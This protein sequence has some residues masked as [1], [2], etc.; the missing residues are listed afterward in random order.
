MNRFRLPAIQTR[1]AQLAIAVMAVSLGWALSPGNIKSYLILSPEAVRS[2]M[3]WQCVSYLFIAPT[4]GSVFWS[5]LII[6][7][8]GGALEA[9]WRSRRFL[10]FAIAVPVLA[11]VATFLLSLVWTRLSWA[12][13]VGA[14]VLSSAIW[15]AYG[16]SLGSQ[17]VNLFGMLPI[18]GNG[19]AW[20]GLAFVVYDGAYGDWPQVVPDGFALAFTFVFVK[21]GSPYVWWLRFQSQRLQ[22][23]LSKKHAH[24]RVVEKTSSRKDY[25]N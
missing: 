18:S 22:K 1:A 14:P 10:Q 19:L 13:Y 6:W 15:V 5:A 20:L 11:G 9:S 7:S 2:G 4:P 12:A 8:S 24:L 16:L 21:Y 3:L 23:K 17:R 25:L